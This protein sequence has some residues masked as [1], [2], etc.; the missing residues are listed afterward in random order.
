MRK[1]GPQH[2]WHTPHEPGHTRYMNALLSSHWSSL[3]QPG[4]LSSWS[5]HTVE[6]I[7]HES[8]H[9]FITAI[10][11]ARHSPA[12]SA[13]QLGAPDAPRSLGGG[14]G[15]QRAPASLQIWHCVELPSAHFMSSHTPHDSGHVLNMKPALL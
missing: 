5:M 2:T 6:Q 12:S 7:S 15:K 14:S 4:Q 13:A 9:S 3:A 11:F 8:G 1:L 10:G